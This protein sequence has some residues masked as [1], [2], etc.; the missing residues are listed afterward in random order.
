MKFLCSQSNGTSHSKTGPGLSINRVTLAKTPN[1]WVWQVYLWLKG[2]DLISKE[3]AFHEQNS[4][5]N[6]A[7]RF[8]QQH[9]EERFRAALK[10]VNVSSSPA[11]KMQFHMSCQLE[12]LYEQNIYG[13]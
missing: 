4:Q 6:G 9:T 11:N 12:G 1:L 10:K 2:Y 7:H 13:I 3:A 5:V 8:I